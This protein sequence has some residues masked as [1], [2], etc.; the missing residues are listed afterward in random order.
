MKG[1][2][3]YLSEEDKKKIEYWSKMLEET[4]KRLRD[5]DIQFDNAINMYDKMPFKDRYVYYELVMSMTAYS[6]LLADTLASA[7]SYSPSLR[8]K[9]NSLL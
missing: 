3:M 8:E 5:Y 4:G 9:L 6:S 2:T 1:I 7:T